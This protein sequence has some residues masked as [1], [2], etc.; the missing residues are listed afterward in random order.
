M[1]VPLPVRRRHCFT[2]GAAHAEVGSCPS[3]PDTR[4]GELMAAASR[5]GG[6]PTPAE[7]GLVHCRQ[8]GRPSSPP[9]WR[10]LVVVVEGFDQA[11]AH[12]VLLERYVTIKKN[13]RWI[14]R[15]CEAVLYV[16]S[17]DAARAS[18]ADLLA[19]ARGRYQ[20]KALFQ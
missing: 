12:F 14:M 11:S 13:G 16:T 19:Y 18:P 7:G 15:N 3:V 6:P 20:P 10:L 8:P 17:L 2:A 9:G 5:P 1:P 4:C